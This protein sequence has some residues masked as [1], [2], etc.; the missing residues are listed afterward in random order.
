MNDIA[1]ESLKL[2]NVES[3][4]I[5]DL[6]KWRNHPV[7]RENSF[8]IEP[9]SLDEHER[10]FKEKSKDP[11]SQIYIAYFEDDKIGI[12]RFDEKGD[13]I[14]VNVM[15]NPDFLGK[16]IGSE[17][18]R[19]GTE[20]FINDKN[21]GKPVIAEIKKDNIASIKAFQKA[22]FKESHSTFVY[23]QKP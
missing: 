14:K 19:L 8:N 23:Q 13:V 4:D 15:L 17:V 5:G 7:V 1:K 12:V 6:F 11:N 2:R 21:P 20:R 22:A 9:I 18:I 10:W 3:S 16:G